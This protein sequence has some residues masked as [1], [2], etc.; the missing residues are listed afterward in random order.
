MLNVSLISSKSTLSTLKY[1]NISKRISSGLSILS[2][3]T[4]YTLAALKDS[5]FKKIVPKSKHGQT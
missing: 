2:A 1:Q 3:R 4:N 5:V